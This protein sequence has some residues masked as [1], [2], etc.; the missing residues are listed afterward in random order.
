MTVPYTALNKIKLK[1]LDLLRIFYELGPGTFITSFTNKNAILYKDFYLIHYT[2][3]A[4][5]TLSLELPYSFES[6]LAHFIFYSYF[7]NII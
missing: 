7:T 4:K 2:L 6:D 5:D 3:K 1:S